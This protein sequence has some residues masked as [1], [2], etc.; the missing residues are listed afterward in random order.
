MVVKVLSMNMPPGVGAHI[1][2]P[3]LGYLGKRITKSA[4]HS[5]ILFLKKENMRIS[6]LT[7]V[8]SL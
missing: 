4:L 6:G 2:N 1:C 3:A 8:I 5:E 7:N